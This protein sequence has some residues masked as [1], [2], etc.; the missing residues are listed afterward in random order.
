MSVKTYGDQLAQEI[1][2]SIG[3][4]YASTAA[5]TALPAAKRI[6]GMICLVLA[7]YSLWVFEAASATGASAT[8]LAPDAG[9]GR[10][11]RIALAE[12]A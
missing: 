11:H 5:L 7:N 4:N 12:V 8:V 1:T 2:R 9:T 10:W 3:G 6:D